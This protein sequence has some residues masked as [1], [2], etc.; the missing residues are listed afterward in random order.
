MHK[1][2]LSLFAVSALS[3]TTTTLHAQHGCVH[4]PEAP[5]GVLM[6]VG[7]VGMTYGASWLRTT[8]ARL[9]AR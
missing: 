2:R 5:T 3:L 8:V 1:V 4:S 9:R 6:L 7:S